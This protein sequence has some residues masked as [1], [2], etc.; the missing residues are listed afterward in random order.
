[1]DAYTF[2]LKPILLSRVEE[3]MAGIDVSV[4]QTDDSFDSVPAGIVSLEL[5][6]NLELVFEQGC[7]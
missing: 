6:P 4:Q 5:K 1:M 3:E 7:P 2:S